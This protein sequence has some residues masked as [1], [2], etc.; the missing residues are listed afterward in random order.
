[1]T[2]LVTGATGFIGGAVVR[3]AATSDWIRTVSRSAIH[4]AERNV[5]SFPA[6]LFT[7]AGIAAALDGA[8][9]L[10]H[11]VSYVG[12]DPENAWRVNLELARDVIRAAE[13]RN[14]HPLIYVSTTGV[15]GAGLMR[16]RGDALP[17]TAPASEV[18]RSRRAAE[19][20][21]L[22]AG[23]T[24]IRPHLLYGVGD[25]WVIP[26]L[27][28]VAMSSGLPDAGSAKVSL[29]DVEFLAQQIWALRG[30]GD[31]VTSRAFNSVNGEPIAL[32]QVIETLHASIPGLW[33]RRGDAPLLSAHQWAMLTMDNWFASSLPRELAAQVPQFR[34]TEQMKTWYAATIS[35]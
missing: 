35:H 25:R 32:S 33:D 18:S 4:G 2:T 16:G 19:E 28:R 31:M 27:S 9:S 21:F 24:V 1:M 29:L 14:I 10:I 34:I 3:G 13:L 11:C 15:Y 6:D 23:G 5:E 8:T 26:L 12:R 7:Q 30:A 17:M 22:A 20:V